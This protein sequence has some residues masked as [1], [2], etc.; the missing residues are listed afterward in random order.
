MEGFTV[1]YLDKLIIRWE[2]SA[3]EL[4]D[5][6]RLITLLIADR[7]VNSGQVQLPV[8]GEVWSAI[9]AYVTYHEEDINLGIDDYGEL[10]PVWDHFN[11][12]S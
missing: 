10:K 2:N 12:N 6:E 5:A 9:V 4:R 1:G 7:E 8:N 3:L 11:R